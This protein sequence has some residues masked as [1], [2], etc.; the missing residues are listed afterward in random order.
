MA[1]ESVSSFL[2]VVGKQISI[3]NRVGLIVIRNCV[4]DYNYSVTVTEISD[5][6]VINVS[7]TRVIVIETF[8]YYSITFH[9]VYTWT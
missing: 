3:S 7:Y 8:N 1:S 4:N 5:N 9:F 6:S 2:T